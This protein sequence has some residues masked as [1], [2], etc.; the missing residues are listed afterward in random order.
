M[1]ELGSETNDQATAAQEIA[2]MAPERMS[3]LDRWAKTATIKIIARV[4]NANSISS[5]LERST[6]TFH[7]GERRG[8]DLS[9]PAR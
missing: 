1:G 6:S 9:G 5:S 4:K 8:K 3:R 7:S 2:R